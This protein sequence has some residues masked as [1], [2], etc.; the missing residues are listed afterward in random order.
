LREGLDGANHVDL[1]R[2]ISVREQRP[3][4]IQMIGHCQGSRKIA[5]A[6]LGMSIASRSAGLRVSN[7]MEHAGR[8]ISFVQFVYQSAD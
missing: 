8:L 3:G 2:E 5:S 4:G 1:V 6:S 7:V